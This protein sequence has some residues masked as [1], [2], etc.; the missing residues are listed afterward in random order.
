MSSVLVAYQ[1]EIVAGPFLGLFLFLWESLGG[2]VHDAQ[3]LECL[4]VRGEE[5]VEGSDSDPLV[6]G[7]ELAH[8]LPDLILVYRRIGVD[9]LVD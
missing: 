7:Q 3:E 9:D 4:L 1:E 5:V 6:L 8:P 2:L